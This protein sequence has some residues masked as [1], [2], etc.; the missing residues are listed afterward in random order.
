VQSSDRHEQPGYKGPAGAALG[1]W[2]TIA[3]SVFQTQDRTAH[4]D[5]VLGALDV[6]K[7]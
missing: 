5:H 4:S 6:E 3:P 1:A 2:L 7:R